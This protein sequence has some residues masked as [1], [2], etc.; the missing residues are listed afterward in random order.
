MNEARMNCDLKAP[1]DGAIKL[2][3]VGCIE[4]VSARV[5][6]RNS[7]QPIEVIVVSRRKVIE[8]E[9]QYLCPGTRPTPLMRAESP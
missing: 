3:S 7:A 6:D 9:G 8:G 1:P 5:S 2:R 4:N